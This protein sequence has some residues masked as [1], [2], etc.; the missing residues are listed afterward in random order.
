MYR[1]HFL[2]LLYT[3]AIKERTGQG[4]R[5]CYGRTA[6]LHKAGQNGKKKNWKHSFWNRKTNNISNMGPLLNVILITNLL[7]FRAGICD[8]KRFEASIALSEHRWIRRLRTGTYVC[9]TAN[10]LSGTYILSTCPGHHQLSDRWRNSVRIPVRRN[11][12]PFGFVTVKVTSLFN[13][14]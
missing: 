14:A 11:K 2:L 9:M 4:L 8:F 6:G 5:T 10:I 12:A 3:Y 13:T 7:S 1:T